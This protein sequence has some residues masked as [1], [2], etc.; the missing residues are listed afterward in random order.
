MT[1]AIESA[2]RLAFAPSWATLAHSLLSPEGLDSL[3]FHMVP[4]ILPRNPPLVIMP[5]NWQKQKKG[6]WYTDKK[7]LPKEFHVMFS[8]M[9][10]STVIVA[11]N[12]EKKLFA[13][14]SDITSHG[15]GGVDRVIKIIQD[16]LG[17]NRKIDIYHMRDPRDLSDTSL[18]IELQKRLGS[19]KEN[20][21]KLFVSWEEIRKG[22][23]IVYSSG[24]LSKILNYH[25]DKIVDISESGTWNEEIIGCDN[26]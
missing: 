19:S 21:H 1:I 10:S 11:E 24:Q 8:S 25:P 17:D 22:L 23:N 6:M 9:G 18:V 3:R 16:V 2:R 20:L 14:L 5:S 12:E 26:G 13:H 4:T 15:E 7:T